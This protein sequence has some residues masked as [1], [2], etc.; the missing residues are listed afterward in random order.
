MPLSREEILGRTLGNITVALP[1]ESGTVII[2][3]LNRDEVIA[4]GRVA[5][6]DEG[7]EG[8][9]RRHNLIVALGLVD[10][11][12]SVADVEHWAANDLGNTVLAVANKIAEISGM[13]EG[14]GKSG[15][16]RTR[17]KPRS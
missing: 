1:D 12:L 5:E 13:T 11:A 16:P 8:T 14:A 4:V 6:D 9:A 15:L 17:R 2:R 7:D 10:P 3:P